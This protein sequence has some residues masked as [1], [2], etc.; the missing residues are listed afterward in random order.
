MRTMQGTT[1]TELLIALAVAGVLGSIAAP[2]MRHFHQQQQSV[3]AVNQMIVAVQFARH[4]AVAHRTTVTLCPSFDLEN[5]A[6]RD[7]WHAGAIVFTDANGNGHRDPGDVV[8][9]G[10]GPLPGDGRIYWRSF[11][12]RTYL[13]M[14]PTGLTNWQNGNFLYCPANGDPTL[15]RGVI[16]NA[17][18]RVRTA[19][20]RDA[21][22][23]PLACP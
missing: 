12:N 4:A 10:F 13:Q 11:R 1:T 2:S 20:D 16:V 6:A 8:L 23:R 3:A 15:A 14:T 18:G 9:R 22:G 5:C 19:R 21:S 17:Q 7:Q